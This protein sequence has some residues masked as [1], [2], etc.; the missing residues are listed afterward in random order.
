METASCR[1]AAHICVMN[2]ISPQ[3]IL[4]P[5][6]YTIEMPMTERKSTGSN[7]ASLVRSKSP[8]ITMTAMTR[9]SWISKSDEPCATAVFTSSPES[10]T[11]FAPPA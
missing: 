2:E 4:V 10:A 3:M 5:R 6:L 1:I 9:M 8:R 11:A 7:Q